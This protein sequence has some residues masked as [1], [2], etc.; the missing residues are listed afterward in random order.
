MPSEHPDVCQKLSVCHKD[1]GRSEQ[2]DSVRKENDTDEDSIIRSPSKPSSDDETGLSEVDP[3]FV[4]LCWHLEVN[5][6]ACQYLIGDLAELSVKKMSDLMAEKWRPDWFCD[7]AKLCFNKS[8]DK[9]VHGMIIKSAGKHADALIPREDFQSLSFDADFFK[10]MIPHAMEARSEREKNIAL[11][12]QAVYK[13]RG[14]LKDQDITRLQESVETLKSFRDKVNSVMKIVS[15]HK[16]CPSC[17]R[18]YGFHIRQ[19]KRNFVPACDECLEPYDGDL[20]LPNIF[21]PWRSFKRR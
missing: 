11:Q 3:V 5:S 21:T 2:H 12:A 19:I 17:K 13:A 14:K 16:K 9:N 4:E 15:H 1:Q 20:S 18:K 10:K 6:L 8:D 7:F